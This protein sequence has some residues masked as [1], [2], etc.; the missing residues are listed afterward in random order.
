MCLVVWTFSEKR[1]D[2]TLVD[3]LANDFEWFE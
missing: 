2:G 3:F 1:N